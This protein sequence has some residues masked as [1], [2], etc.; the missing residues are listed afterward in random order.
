MDVEAA[1]AEIKAMEDAMDPE[2]R[3]QYEDFKAKLG[4]DDI[5]WNSPY[6]AVRPTLCCFPHFLCAGNISFIY[7]YLEASVMFM[8]SCRWVRSL[9]S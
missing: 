6:D 9:T 1:E 3:A 4:G 8:L 2:E 5:P 7:T